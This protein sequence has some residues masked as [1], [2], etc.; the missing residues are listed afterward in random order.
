MKSNALRFVHVP[1]TAGV[2][3]RDAFI[4]YFGA[5]RVA[6]GYST[7]QDGFLHDVPT[8]SA[9]LV[10]VLKERGIRVYASHT[11]Y[12][13]NRDIFYP[14]NT[15]VFIRNPVE[16][17]ISDYYHMVRNKKFVGSFEA[18]KKGKAPNLFCAYIS[19][20]FTTAL[21]MLVKVCLTYTTQTAL[22][23]S[24]TIL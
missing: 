23:S 13:E 10:R 17:L 20:T 3:L 1:K 9:A 19:C 24:E 18:F 14:K 7:F 5:N 16:R 2:S 21:N 11:F 6:N 8:N 22:I 15:I 12:E 4:E